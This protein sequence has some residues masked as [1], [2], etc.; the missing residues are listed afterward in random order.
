MFITTVTTIGFKL[1]E[2]YERMQ[3]FILES[4]MNEWRKNE[5]TSEYTYFTKTTYSTM[6]IRGEQTD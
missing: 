4:D 6:T 2:E 5:D 1:P 3:R